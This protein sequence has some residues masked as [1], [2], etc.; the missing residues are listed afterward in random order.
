MTLRRIAAVSYLNTIPFIHGINHAGNDLRAE[1][2]LSPPKGCAQAL[3]NQSADIALIPVAAIPALEPLRIIT[4]YCI[5]ASTPVRTVVLVSNSPVE[6]IHTLYLDSHSITSATLVRVLAAELWN[7][8]PVWKELNDYTLLDTPQPG[9]A[10]L[11]IGDKVFPQEGRFACTYDLAEAW[12]ELTAL[13]FVFAAWVARPTVSQEVIDSLEMALRYGVNH[14][15]EAIAASEYRDKSYAYD[16]LTHNIDF[17]FDEQKRRAMQL[18][19][20]KGMKITP[21][22][23]PG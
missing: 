20:E 9:T 1:F 14:I 10:Y 16:Y 21:L 11:L 8:T 22:V 12:R 17:R 6:Q 3:Y 4:P 23:N 19:W 13:P 15:E 18:F 5:G 2:L 7:I